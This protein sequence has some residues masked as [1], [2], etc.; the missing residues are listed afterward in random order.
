MDLRL[1]RP[2]RYRVK[3]GQ[4]VSSI[5]RTYSLPPALLAAANDLKEEV[6]AGDIL[7]I[8]ATEGDLY[9][10][11]GG[12]SR[13]LLCGSAEKFEEKNGTSLLYIGQTVLL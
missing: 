13:A 3:R 6:E 8:P 2:L 4:T 1:I 5:A 10:V 7:L 11:R 9:T 12:E